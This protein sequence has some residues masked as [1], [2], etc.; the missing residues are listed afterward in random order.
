MARGSGAERGV[1]P[2][3]R[4]GAVRVARRADHFGQEGFRPGV[5]VQD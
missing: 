2:H 5:A 1:G 4:H 3:R